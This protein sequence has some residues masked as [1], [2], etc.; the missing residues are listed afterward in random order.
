[1]FGKCRNLNYRNLLYGVLL[2]AVLITGFSYYKVLK[3]FRDEGA[4]TVPRN[5]LMSIIDLRKPFS[6]GDKRMEFLS[7]GLFEEDQVAKWA[8][9]KY[10]SS[11]FHGAILYEL[12]ISRNCLFN[13]YRREMKNQIQADKI[14]HYVGILKKDL[15]KY[16]YKPTVAIEIGAM[17]IMKSDPR[18]DYSKIRLSYDEQEGWFKEAFND[19]QW[20]LLSLP[21]YTSH[22]PVEYPPVMKTHWN[23]EVIFVRMNLFFGLNDK[24]L[25]LGIGFPNYDPFEYSE[26]LETI[27]VNGAEIGKSEFHETAY[28]WTIPVSAYVRKG[29]NLLALKLRVNK[30]S[31][32]D[33]YTW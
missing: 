29:E 10:D 17:A 31:D 24:K 16:S 19:H 13:R 5:V 3:Y 7:I 12:S 21:V 14:D 33:I 26:N 8:A 18:I 15:V 30:T 27:Y 1:M 25:F 2:T 20:Q 22:D 11:S 6:L 32:L 28:G 9:E 23:K 4:F